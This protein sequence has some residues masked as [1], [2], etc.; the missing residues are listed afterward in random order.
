VRD[1]TPRRHAA[2]LAWPI[3]S[4]T[5]SPDSRTFGRA[6][7]ALGL[8]PIATGLY[9]VVTGAGGLT[10]ESDAAVNVDSELRFLYA[11]WIAYGA[12]IVYVGLRA[13]DSRF[14]VTAIAAIL[15]CA[16]VARGISWIVEGRPDALYLVL[17]ALEL[18]IPPVLVAWQRMSVGPSSGGNVHANSSGQRSSR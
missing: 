8:V 5:E 2:L 12:A 16:G 9:G 10:G 15:F 3:A 13:A 18:A 6:L 11:F 4:A 17:L 1:P 7:A 14:A